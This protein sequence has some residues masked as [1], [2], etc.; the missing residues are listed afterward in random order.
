MKAKNR[1]DGRTVACK[2][3]S[4]VGKDEPPDSKRV[5]S[6]GAKGRRSL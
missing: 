3:P 2:K 5:D 4:W 1:R 6:T